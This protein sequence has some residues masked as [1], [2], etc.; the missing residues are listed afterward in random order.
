VFSSAAAQNNLG[1]ALSTLGE[2]ENGTARLDDAVTAFRD[3]LEE[4]T[5]EREPHWHAI[6]QRNLASC[7][8]LLAQRR[9]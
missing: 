1:V 2:R 7:L 6:A 4:W 5:R 8:V 3:A 9:E